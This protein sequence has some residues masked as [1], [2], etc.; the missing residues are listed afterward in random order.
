MN[1]AQCHSRQ[2]LP[3]SLRQ[4]GIA[5][6]FMSLTIV[7]G[8]SSQPPLGVLQE[9]NIIADGECRED[10]VLVCQTDPVNGLAMGPRSSCGC[11]PIGRFEQ[12]PMRDRLSKWR[13]NH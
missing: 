11:Q 8:C 10:W 12:P 1:T 3:A 6:G 4:I 9:N 7:A 5:I 2:R 13:T